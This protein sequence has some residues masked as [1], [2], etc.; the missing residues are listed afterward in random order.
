VAAEGI[1]EDWVELGNASG[2]DGCGSGRGGDCGGGGGDGIGRRRRRW[3]GREG[4]RRTCEAGE[5]G[6][7][8]P[9]GLS[10]N[11]WIKNGFR[12]GLVS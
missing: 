1:G 2:S 7:N 5:S 6:A 3:E 11:P 9:R 12:E 4:E 8:G 10:H